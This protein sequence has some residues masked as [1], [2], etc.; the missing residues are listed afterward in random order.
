MVFRNKDVYRYLQCPKLFYREYISEEKG[1]PFIY[2]DYSLSELAKKYLEIDENDAFIGSVGQSTFDTLEGWGGKTWCVNGRF[3][4]FS[5]REKI[6]FLK[7][8]EDGVHYI[9]LCT[10]NHPKEEKVA[11]AYRA[12]WLLEKCGVAVSHISLLHLNGEYVR[13]GE[14]D[15]KKLFVLSPCYYKDNNRPGKSMDEAVAAYQMDMKKVL[16]E[17]QQTLTQQEF[18]SPW[19]LS[20]TRSGKCKY[21]KECFEEDSLSDDSIL[22]LNGSRKKYNMYQEGRTSMK[23]LTFDEI[24][25]N[26]IQ[27]AQYQSAIKNDDFIDYN[28]LSYFVETYL[29]EDLIYVDFE[30]DTIGIPMYDGM[31]PYDVM[32]FQYS[33]HMFEN[34]NL[35]HK[36]FLADGGDSRLEFIQHLLNDIP[37]NGT[38]LAYNADGAEVIRLQELAREFPDYADELLALSKRF[39]DLSYP[40]MQGAIYLKKMRNTFSLK[41]I[42]SVIDPMDNYGNLDIDHGLKAVEV[43]RTLS[44]LNEEEKK[45]KRAELLAYCGMDTL[46][47][48][49]FVAY[50]KNCIAMKKKEILEKYGRI[51]E[52]DC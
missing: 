32:P 16:E 18:A 19:T 37:P 12:K 28:G 30:W 27:W 31:K 52:T 5:Y 7:R 11:Q 29:Q 25:G 13:Q 50:L 17:M 4:A 23:D 47:M 43:Y 42:L 14:L 33:I 6:S 10:T 3:E 49:K 26:Y 40:I 20:C 51:E 9:M 45:E 8:E 41:K 35:V 36:E 44:N 15:I 1:F 38:L 2:F 46:A 21:Y 48:V 24:D 39:I 22:F 34:G